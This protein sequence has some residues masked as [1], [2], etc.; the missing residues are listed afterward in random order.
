[1]DLNAQPDH[2]GEFLL[3]LTNTSD[4]SCDVGGWVDL[5]PRNMADEPITQVPT[6]K[7]EHPG[8]PVQIKLEP[9]RTAFAGVRAELGDKADPNTYVASGFTAAPTDMDGEVNADVVGSE[10]QPVQ[11]PLKSLQIGTLQP[12]TDGVLF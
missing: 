3:A 6:D 11:I 2:P 7:I 9:G 4:K 8:A 1:M 10:G 12:I 5:V